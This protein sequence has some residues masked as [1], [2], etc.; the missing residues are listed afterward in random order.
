[1]TPVGPMQYLTTT[2]RRRS[3]ILIAPSDAS[4]KCL[5]YANPATVTAAVQSPESQC[6]E[7]ILWQCQG[8]ASVTVD[9]RL[10]PRLQGHR[11][12]GLGDAGL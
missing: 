7:L 6:K 3:V 1:V 10:P 12:P 5:A 4:Q 2:A 8:L 11:E 9:S